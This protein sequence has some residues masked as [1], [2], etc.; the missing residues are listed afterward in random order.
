MSEFVHRE[1]LESL[2]FKIG[3]EV[4]LFW[5]ALAQTPAPTSAGAGG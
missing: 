3:H 4:A 5:S 1:N 2:R